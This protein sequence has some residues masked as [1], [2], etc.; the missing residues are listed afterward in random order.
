MRLSAQRSYE[1]WRGAIQGEK[2][3]C[4]QSVRSNNNSDDIGSMCR[5]TG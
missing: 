2:K 4:T 1:E 5:Q 3:E